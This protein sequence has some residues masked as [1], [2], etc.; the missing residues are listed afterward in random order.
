M[1]LTFTDINFNICLVRTVQSLSVLHTPAFEGSL[2][3]VGSQ[4]CSKEE[5]AK[6]SPHSAYCCGF[7]PVWVLCAVLCCDRIPSPCSLRGEGLILPLVFRC[8]VHQ[9]REGV[10]AAAP[11]LGFLA[12]SLRSAQGAEEGEPG[13][14]PLSSSVFF[15]AFSFSL[16]S[17]ILGWSPI[18]P[19]VL[20]SLVICLWKCPHRLA[21]GRVSPR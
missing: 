5:H 15:S 7:I 17:Q 21:Q 9:S 8:T 19:S 13:A 3:C 6:A 18:F 16:R 14:F 10:V 11:R 2:L 12:S 20:T 1:F 4:K